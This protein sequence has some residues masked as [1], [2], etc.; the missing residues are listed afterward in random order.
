M[1]KLF[2]TILTLASLGFVGSLNSQSTASAATLG[3]PQFRIQIGR[4]R[5]RDR[6]YRDYRDRDYRARGDRVG[7]SRTFTRDVRSGWRIYRETYQV[8]SLPNGQTRT[9]LISRVQ[10][11]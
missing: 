2:A 4:Q 5:R 1:K 9:M 8:R 10:I 11:R 3:K 7:Y 6:D